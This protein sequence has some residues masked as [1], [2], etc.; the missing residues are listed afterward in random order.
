MKSNDRRAKKFVRLQKSMTADLRG[1]E[2]LLY[3]NGHR[4]KGCEPGR[5][6]VRMT[7]VVSGGW[8][9]GEGAQRLLH[10]SSFSGVYAFLS[11]FDREAQETTI[12][13]WIDDTVAHN[14][15]SEA[16]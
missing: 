9:H 15:L 2:D 16:A 3:R 12:E 4:V 8:G 5:N 10:S 6:K 13:A 7:I 11:S 1:M 14:R